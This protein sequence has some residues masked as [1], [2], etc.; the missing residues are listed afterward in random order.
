MRNLIK[1]IVK[2][3]KKQVVNQTVNN[4]VEMQVKMIRLEPSGKNIPTRRSKELI[5]AAVNVNPAV[6]SESPRMSYSE[7]VSNARMV[8]E[9]YRRRFAS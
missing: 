9:Y 8:D 3:F 4:V 2:L 1:R 6:V 7:W 5:Q